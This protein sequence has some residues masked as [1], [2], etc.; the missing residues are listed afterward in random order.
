MYTR[1]KVSISA[2]VALVALGLFAG[3]K[4]AYRDTSLTFEER[5]VDLVSRMTLDEK[6]GQLGRNSIAVPRLGLDKYDYWNEALHG[7]Q[8]GTGEGTS[9]P[10]PLSL[11]QTWDEEFIRKV[12][13]A[14]GDECRGHS[15]P[16]SEGGRGRGLTYWC[17]T[18][19]LARH[20]LWG[21]TNEAYG[22]DPYVAGRLA[23]AFVEGMKGDDPRYLKT[24]PTIKHYALNNHENGRGS[25]SS[26]ASDADIRDYYARVYRYIVERTDVPSLMSAYNAVNFTPSS[27]NPFLLTT[28]LRDTFGFTGFVVSDCG[29]IDNLERQQKWRPRR[30]TVEKDNYRLRDGVPLEKYVDADGVVTKPGSVAMAMMAGCDMDCNGDIYPREARKAYAAGLLDEGQL[31]IN[32]YR[33]LLSR[34]KLG[35]FDPVED[36]AYNGAEYSFAAAVETPEHRALADEAASRS[37][38]LL[39]NDDG[40]LPLNARKLRRIAVVGELADTCF[41][42]NYCGK[43]KEKNRISPYAGIVDYLYVHNP[44]AAVSLVTS[45]GENGEIRAE[46]R[47]SIETA[48]VVLVVCADEHGDSSEGHDRTQLKL[49]R[50][51]A[52]IARN[53]AALNPDTIV[54]LQTANVVELDVFKNA[55]KAILWSSHNGQGQGTGLAN[56]VFGEVNP[57]GKL[58][59]T[60]Y[61][62]ESQLPGIRQYGLK[63]KFLPDEKPYPCGGFTYQYFG[64]DVEYPFGY[65]L[66][67]TTFE[68]AN[69]KIDRTSA[70]ANDKIRV[71]VDVKNTGR[72]EGSEI[73]QAYVAYPKGRG[74]P[75]KQI[76]GFAKIDLKPGETK[77]ADIEIDVAD[78]CFW[79]GSRRVVPNGT[80]AV[81]I[82]ASSADIKASFPV[83]VTGRLAAKLGVVAAKPADVVVKFGAKMASGLSITLVDDSF[84]APAA[85]KT[86][87][88]SSNEAVAKV[89]GAGM[90]Y[91]VAPGTA[92][93]TARVEYNGSVKTAGFPVAVVPAGGAVTPPVEPIRRVVPLK[94]LAKD[95]TKVDRDALEEAIR[96]KVRG[97]DYDPGTLAA[98]H[99]GIK[100]ARKVFFDPK[101]TQAEVDA[102]YGELAAVKSRLRDFRHI[103]ADF[104][105]ANRTWPFGNGN[106]WVNWTNAKDAE[107]RDTVADFTGHDPRKLELRFT[108]TLT[109]SDYTIPFADAVDGGSFIK[110]RSVNVAQKDNDPDLQV[111]GGSLTSND[112][113]NYGWRVQD[114]VTAWGRTEVAV[115]LATVN[116]D[117]STGLP[118]IDKGFKA[119]GSKRYSRGKIDWSRI[120]RFFMNINFKDRYRKRLSVTTKIENC[121]VVDVTLE[122]ERE[123]LDAMLSEKAGDVACDCPLKRTAYAEAVA[124]AKAALDAGN[125]G[126]VRKA[127]ADLAA[128][129]E[130]A[131]VRTTVDKSALS[132]AVGARVKTFSRYTPESVR[133]YKETVRKCAE[134]LLADNATQLDVNRAARKAA[135]APSLLKLERVTPRVIA[136]LLDEESVERH[137]L[138]VSVPANVDLSADGDYRVTVRYQIKFESTH[139][140]RPA[141][142]GWLKL[143]V[144]GRARVWGD[145]DSRGESAIAVASMSCL[146]DSP[147]AV[148]SKP[149]EWMTV[150][151]E[152]PVAKLAGGR[153]TRFET[154]LFNDTGAY[155]G[156]P[157]EGIDWNNDSGV[158]MTVRGV[159]VLT[160]RP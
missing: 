10:M 5:A 111:F 127:M 20:P 82:G 159:E 153:L 109:P 130:D 149:G 46:D 24:V 43:P 52:E 107:G 156:E 133:E 65:G 92:T 17:P 36:V 87:Y 29:A 74:L 121:R 137:H 44:R 152:I 7:I 113:H 125:V 11:A 75:A 73:V 68:Y 155:Q 78:C 120:D 28:L 117:G 141:G 49:Y 103:V 39:K 72:R 62:K 99:D 97:D 110:L 59:F 146:R 81:E 140:K 115:P 34:F 35:E 143:L 19:N 76:K 56:Q 66:S 40:I 124:K 105:Q 158:K 126:V 154:Y 90:V 32:I 83:N 151:H 112:E 55:V 58:T 148:Y 104:R 64:G 9:F 48:D 33:S 4:P 79:D 21:R 53:A 108:V 41:L 8:N 142:D 6:F 54:F 57:Y 132:A 135:A 14:I 128:A 69:A 118:C 23:S 22:E 25:T 157:G 1:T 134:T 47:E 147:L 98:Y 144:N 51:Q 119:D 50:A 88:K 150:E 139:A 3:E 61:A 100:K 67:Y 45:F 91:G 89:D 18:V 106:V 86:T 116:P 136:K 94:P 80:Y 30:N 38:V 123:K 42:G 71:S 15:R 26:D 102:A 145:T 16:A 13:S 37:V 122:E 70:D 138:C 131:G 60:W 2:I 101:A 129:R 93:I 31:N 84:L 160:D 95:A 63:E 85:A 77:R 27:G 114:Y 96:V 12:A